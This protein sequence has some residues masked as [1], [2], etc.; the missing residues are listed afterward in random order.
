MILAYFVGLSVCYAFVQ[1]AR[2]A[3][4]LNVEMVL[5]GT[6][7]IKGPSVHQLVARSLVGGVMM[8]AFLFLERMWFCQSFYLIGSHSLRMHRWPSFLFSLCFLTIFHLFSSLRFSVFLSLPS[9]SIHLCVYV[10]YRLYFLSFLP[11]SLVPIKY[12]LLYYILL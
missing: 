5:K 7:V 12:I 10:F 6:E 3:R 2:N 8:L 9:F 1:S 11:N 4:I